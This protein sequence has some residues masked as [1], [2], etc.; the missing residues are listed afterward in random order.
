MEMSKEALS[1]LIILAVDPDIKTVLSKYNQE[2]SSENIH[3][4]IYKLNLKDLK[5]TAKFLNNGEVIDYLSN[6]TLLTPWIIAQIKN[7]LPETCQTC[8]DTYCIEY[9]M[10]PTVKCSLCR[11][12]AHE[13]CVKDFLPEG[14]IPAL[15]GMQWICC[16]CEPKIKLLAGT[17]DTEK[18]SSVLEVN[19]TV[20]DTAVQTQEKSLTTTP[21]TATSQV[22]TTHG[23]TILAETAQDKKAANIT[24]PEKSQ[25]QGE[26]KK[27]TTTPNTTTFQVDT[28]HGGTLQTKTTQDEKTAQITTPENSKQQGETKKPI[29]IH[30]RNNKCKYGISGKGCDYTH[31]KLCR[32]FIAFGH[33]H[34]KGCTAGSNCPLFH[35]KMCHCSM[36]TGECYKEECRFMHRKGTKRVR[37]SATTPETSS[38]QSQAQKQT[39]ISTNEQTTTNTQERQN[40]KNQENGSFLEIIQQIQRSLQL[41]EVAQQNQANLIQ[42]L[43]AHKIHQVPIQGPQTQYATQYAPY[44]AIQPYPWVHNRQ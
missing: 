24:S 32:K 37:K 34:L 42:G 38:Q 33:K 4:N 31:P 7:L 15:V 30:F 2:S 3:R 36:N 8:G 35:P 18:K 21:N 44:P 25:Q 28:T 40:R 5:K 22:D 19:A 14:Q 26:T 39:E 23:G 12:G 20:K 43:M 11:Q 6:K 16:N 9:G 13:K 17:S 27:T 29:C 1:N 41:M 10:E